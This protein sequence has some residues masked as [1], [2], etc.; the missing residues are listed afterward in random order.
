MRQI[1]GI[2]L[3]VL[4]FCSNSSFAGELTESRTA[5]LL[6]V[7]PARGLPLLESRFRVDERQGSARVE[8]AFGGR[9]Y[10]RQFHFT[11]ADLV[12][13]Q[14]RGEINVRTHRGDMVCCGTVYEGLNG[15]RVRETGKCKIR[16]EV[17]PR[18]DAHVFLVHE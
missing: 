4:A 9:N 6:G 8:T 16:A 14:A 1:L 5:L 12:W 18:G 3:V 17:A 11:S 13:D 7:V 2:G 15:L 10:V